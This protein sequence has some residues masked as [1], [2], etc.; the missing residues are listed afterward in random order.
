MAAVS[1]SPSAS[2]TV[3]TSF[4]RSAADRFSVDVSSSLPVFPCQMLFSCVNVISPVPGLTVI[5]K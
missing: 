3:C 5:V 1:L 4:R 2:V